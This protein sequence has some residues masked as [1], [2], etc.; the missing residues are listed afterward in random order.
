MEELIEAVK[1]NMD[2]LNGA[3][4]NDVAV[5]LEA[6]GESIYNGEVIEDL[7]ASIRDVESGNAWLFIKVV[8]NG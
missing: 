5:F 3:D 2:Y 8:Y 1:A 7:A 6:V 4:P